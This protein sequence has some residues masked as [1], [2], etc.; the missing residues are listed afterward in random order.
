MFIGQEYKVFDWF[1]IHFVENNGM[2]FGLEFGGYTGKIILTVFRLIVVAVGIRY[3][4]SLTKQKMRFGAL[5]ALGLIL[6][7]AIGNII[8]SCFYGL[9]FETSYNNV[10]SFIPENGGYAPFL[11]G[12]VV[13]MLYFPLI[14]TNINGYHFIFFRPIFNIADAGISVGAIMILLFYSKDFK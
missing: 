11:Q 4:F 13:D 2:A 6:G 5:I 9:L 10:S 14:N 7:G 12:K 1:F 8:D 3:L